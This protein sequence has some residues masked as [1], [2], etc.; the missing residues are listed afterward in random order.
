MKSPAELFT[1]LLMLKVSSGADFEASR[2]VPLKFFRPEI[3]FANSP[4]GKEHFLKK[5]A[6]RRFPVDRAKIPPRGGFFEQNR[7]LSLRTAICR[8]RRPF[9]LKFSGSL[10]HVKR[11]LHAKFQVYT[12]SG[13]LRIGRD[14]VSAWYFSKFSSGVLPRIYGAKFGSAELW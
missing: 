3:F 2:G 7:G 6:F 10:K 12:A 11:R 5:S 4:N 1:V 9:E 8:T 13:R 14:R